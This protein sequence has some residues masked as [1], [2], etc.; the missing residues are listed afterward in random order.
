MSRPGHGP[1]AQGDF[2]DFVRHAL[3]AAADQVEPR[4]DGLERIREKIRSRPAQASQPRM[5]AIRLA[6]AGFFAQLGG[7]WRQAGARRPA[8]SARPGSAAR[9]RHAPRRPRNWSE[10]MLR[11]ALAIGV[12]VF[13]LGVVLA[14]IPP[15]RN[16]IFNGVQ[17]A[18]SGASSPSSTSASRTPGGASSS[19]LRRPGQRQVGR[20]HHSVAWRVMHAVADTQGSSPRQRL[21]PRRR[22]ARRRPPRRPARR[23]L[24]PRPR[25]LPRRARRTARARRSRRA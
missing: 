2:A 13:A 10:V 20:G 3:H 7:Y 5:A 9:A 14:A 8:A 25:P 4:G 1:Q 12:T 21:R 19:A 6:M 15:L 11:P 23:P 24:R 18:F 22:R 17:A 16:G